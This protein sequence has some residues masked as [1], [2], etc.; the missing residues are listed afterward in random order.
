MSCF[1]GRR[2]AVGPS[3]AALC[4]LLAGCGSGSSRPSN[5]SSTSATPN[6]STASAAAS[7]GYPAGCHAVAAPSLRASESL[8]RPT[9][10]LDPA[11][12]YTVRLRTNCGEIDIALAVRQ[13]PMTTASFTSLVRRGFFDGLTF[14]RVVPGYV[15]Q[16]GDP[17]GNGSGG[18]GYQVI[19][20]PPASLR[21]TPGTVAMAKTASDPSGASGSQFFIVT[22]AQGEALA[23]QYA[24]VGHVVRGRA[25]TAAIGTIATNPPGDG[26]P[27]VPVVIDRASVSGG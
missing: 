10:R 1:P 4:L 27:V 20:A 21:Y 9:L 15:I 3:L 17:A 7:G 2:P 14:H 18:P 8:P 6:S 23:P 13:A 25:A 11:R 12:P 19:E 26:A 5:G 22:G 16:G 24:L